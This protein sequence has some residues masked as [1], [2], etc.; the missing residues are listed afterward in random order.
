MMD[1]AQDLGQLLG[2]SEEYKRLQRA[3]TVLKDD[4][5]AGGLLKQLQQLDEQLRQLVQQGKEPDAGLAEQYDG[6]RQ[7]IEVLA[8]YQAFI[9]AQINFEKLM[10]KVNERIAEGMKKGAESPI[11]TLS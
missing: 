4:Q 7:K 3:D 11:I 9:S 6:L 8:N 10:Q 1:R 5:E 2:Q